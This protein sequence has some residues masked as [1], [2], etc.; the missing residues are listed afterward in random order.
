MQKFVSLLEVKRVNLYLVHSHS[1][2]E[3]SRLQPAPDRR[4]ARC[5][6]RDGPRL[7]PEKGELKTHAIEPANTFI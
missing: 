3:S 5:R 2:V 6:L 4:E 7:A 1:G